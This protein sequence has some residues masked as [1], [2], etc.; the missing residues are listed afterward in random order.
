MVAVVSGS[1]PVDSATAMLRE[2]VAK[3]ASPNTTDSTGLSPLSLLVQTAVEMSSTADVERAAAFIRALVA[4]GA[5]PDLPNAMPLVPR[6]PLDQLTGRNAVILAGALAATGASFA[7]ALYA[8]QH[9]S[10]C[11]GCTGHRFPV[12]P[13]AAGAGT[14]GTMLQSYLHKA[15][16]RGENALLLFAIK[17]ADAPL[18][19]RLPASQQSDTPLGWAI[20]AGQ[21]ETVRML[22]S[23]GADASLAAAVRGFGPSGPDTKHY[24]TTEGRVGTGILPGSF[25]AA[26]AVAMAARSE[27]C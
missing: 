9:G 3:G 6:R 5:D 15:A 25:A 12:A 21:V 4:A 7:P 19:P 16:A 13:G 10:D 17:F 1:C 18:D 14:S 24:I 22:V 23:L 11:C 27:S 2:L 26:L 20:R 8:M